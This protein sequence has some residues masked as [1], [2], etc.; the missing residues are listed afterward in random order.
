MP[1]SSISFKNL[2]RRYYRLEYNVGVFELIRQLENRVRYVYPA[3]KFCSIKIEDAQYLRH[4]RKKSIE[5]SQKRGLKWS[6]IS[7]NAKI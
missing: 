6:E 3:I 4:G 7:N 1:V 5:Q 2:K